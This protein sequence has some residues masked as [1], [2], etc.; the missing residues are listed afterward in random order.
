MVDFREIERVPADITVD[1]A[2]PRINLTGF[3]PGAYTFRLQV[4]DNVGSESAPVEVTVVV[5]RRPSASLVPENE[6]GNT[7]T[8]DR[9][10]GRFLAP[11]GSG[12]VL[13]GASSSDPDG[14]AITTFRWTLVRSDPLG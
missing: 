6:Q 1:A 2:N 10:T 11:A 9:D 7:L 13:N 12:F 4:T 3:P 5:D 14:Q 8:R